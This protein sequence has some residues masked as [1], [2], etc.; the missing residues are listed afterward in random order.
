MDYIE[1]YVSRL[2]TVNHG[3]MPEIVLTSQ[4]MATGIW[5]MEDR[6]VLPDGREMDGRVIIS[7]NM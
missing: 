2:K 7:R 5:S 3:H 1:S 4:T 6:V